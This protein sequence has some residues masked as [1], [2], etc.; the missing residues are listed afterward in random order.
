MHKNIRAQILVCL[1][2]QLAC[3]CIIPSLCVECLQH[4]ELSVCK[5][6]FIGPQEVGRSS[7][8]WPPQNK[9]PEHPKKHPEKIRRIWIPMDI[10]LLMP[11]CINKFRLAD[12]TIA[13]LVKLLKGCN[14]ITGR[15]GS[16]WYQNRIQL[17]VGSPFEVQGC[18]EIKYQMAGPHFA[19][20][21]CVL[22]IIHTKCHYICE[23][24]RSRVWIGTIIMHLLWEV[25][26]PCSIDCMDKYSLLHGEF[27]RG[28]VVS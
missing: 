28:W 26:N 14:H 20:V 5:M 16:Q 24:K 19:A 2:H 13:I 27:C 23:N 15:H 18:K 10:P 9:H 11:R 1:W 21:C 7:M 8:K 22:W 4:L 6:W 12:D 25:K 3:R 17:P